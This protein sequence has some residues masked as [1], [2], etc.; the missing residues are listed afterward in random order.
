[1]AVNLYR[2]HRRDCKSGHR[3]EHLS[4]EFDERKKGWKRCECLIFCSGTLAG[5][6]RRRSTGKWEW[7]E[8]AKPVMAAWEAAGS[9][10]KRPERQPSRPF[11]N[12]LLKSPMRKPS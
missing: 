5:D 7:E 1:M 12:R 8:D 3:E 2:R 11:R 4:S 9:W 10:A 6:Y